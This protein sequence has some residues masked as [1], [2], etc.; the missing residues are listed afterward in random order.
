MNFNGDNAYSY[1]KKLAVDLGP[2]PS[3]TEAERKAAEWILNEFKTMGLKTNLDEFEVVTGKVVSQK[4]E[5]LE[6]YKMEINCEVMPLSG[7][8]GPE[9]ITGELLY[10]DTYDEEYIS[11]DVEGK[12]IITAGQPS[13]RDKA[14]RLL[15]KHK[16]LAIIYVENTPKALAKNLWGSTI[17]KK[18][19]GPLPSLRVSFEDGLKL[20][21]SNAK[22]LHIIANTEE[23]TL[24]SQ[25]VIAE[26]DGSS[27]PEEIILVGGHYD[28]VLEVSGAGDNAGGAAIVMELAR[29][30]KEKGSK[31][32]IRFITW[33]CE[34]LG[35]LGSRDYATKLREASEATKKEK[36][37][38]ITELD[39]IIL[40]LNLDVHGGLIG[41]NS[42]KTLGPPELTSTI[43]VLSKELGIVYNVSEGV[44]SS[45]GTSLSGIGIP[46]ISFSRGTPTNSLMHSRDDDIRWMSPKALEKHGKFIEEFLKRYVAEAVA[47]PF[48]RTIPDKYKKEIEDYFKRAGRKLP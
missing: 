14:M 33:G 9:G 4:L 40:C 18:K 24:K 36:E 15:M 42:S 20:I 35:L 1:L 43:K 3:G 32:T 34:E 45:D 44:Y 10:L 7:S 21:E 37:D 23:M 17:S 8:T 38:A 27:R 39:N 25:N 28:T 19:Y 5:V 16:P 11:N 30:F 31:R 26:L 47:F 13:N 48:E 12:I 29:I 2:R 6:P 22:L 46:S 41:T